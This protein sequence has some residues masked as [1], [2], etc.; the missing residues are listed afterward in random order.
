MIDCPRIMLHAI[1][2]SHTISSYRLTR[3]GDDYFALEKQIKERAIAAGLGDGT[4]KGRK[5]SDNLELKRKELRE[6]KF[7]E[8]L[9]EL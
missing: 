2:T 6:G 5:I 8:R 9:W 7:Y 3:L 1:R 4:L